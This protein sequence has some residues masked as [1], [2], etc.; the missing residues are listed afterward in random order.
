MFFDV[1][2]QQLA[3]AHPLAGVSAVLGELGVEG[4]DF[5]AVGFV[6]SLF[7]VE[8]TR[9]F[10]MVVGDCD[11]ECLGGRFLSSLFH[12]FDLTGTLK[13]SRS[14]PQNPLYTASSK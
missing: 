5:F 3:L 9:D 4:G 13:C 2:E 6:C 12:D 14:K 1:G 8:L 7:L 10:F 11:L